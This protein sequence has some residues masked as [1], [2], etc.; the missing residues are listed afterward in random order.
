MLKP[1][2]IFLLAIMLVVLSCQQKSQSSS[3]SV[4]DFRPSLQPFLLEAIAR[5]LV[6]SY[7]PAILATITDDELAQL[8]RTE[9]PILRA[10]AFKEQMERSNYLNLELLTD[11]LDDTAWV[12]I[13]EGEFGL[14]FRKLADHLLQRAYYFFE[15]KEDQEKIRDLL[16]TKHDNLSYTYYM[17]TGMTLEEKY[18][19][20][21]KKMAVRWRGA[22][23]G[24]E[25]GFEDTERAIYALARFQKPAD[26]PIIRKRLLDNVWDLSDVSFRLM[27]EFPDTSYFQVLQQY[28]QHVFYR[29]SGIRPHGFTGVRADKAAPE[30]F[31][32]ALVAQK[33]QQSA[34]LIDTLFT[35][36]A[37]DPCFPDQE[38]VVD[39]LWERV[40]ESVCP[41]YRELLSHAPPPRVRSIEVPL[42]VPSTNSQ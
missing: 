41:A 2:V 37:D 32:D 29:F 27:T 35:R 28:H 13:D 1:A 8:A 26:I 21:I 31:F 15:Q 23:E 4:K 34:R 40:S 42:G 7:D 39:H 5:G 22:F 3:Y 12:A 18:Y 9:H 14:G 19:E 17:L 38:G 30:D 11:H 36:L 10:M 20:V 25:T 6:K 24:Y 16:L 33:S